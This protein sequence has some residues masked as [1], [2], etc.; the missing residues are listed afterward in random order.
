MGG[1]QNEET[2]KHG[3]NERTDQNS[4]KELNKM[5]TSYLSDAEFKTLVIKMLKGLS[6]DLSSIKKTQ[7]EMKDTLI[8]I[9]NNFQGNN[10]TMDEAENQISNLEYKE[11]QNTQLEQ[12]E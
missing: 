9:K 4:R 5:E 10:N 6:E 7:S 3:P 8:E 2:K 11:T 12:G 1:C